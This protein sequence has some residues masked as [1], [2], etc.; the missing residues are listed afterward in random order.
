MKLPRLRTARRILYVVGDENRP[1]LLWVLLLTIVVAFLD[2]LSIG[3][4]FPLLTTMFNPTGSG[5]S[6]A[7]SF[8]SLPLVGH[9]PSSPVVLGTFLLATFVL[10]AVVSAYS[11]RSGFRFTY[12]VQVSIAQRMLAGLFAKEYE[13]FL[14]QN[15]AVLLKN[16]TAEVQFLAGSVIL[17]AFYV[18]SQ[19]LTI[20]AMVFL[21]GVVSPAAAGISF[22]VI[23]SLMTAMYLLISRR[24]TSWGKARE[25]R[26]S[27]L[28]RLAHEA[29]SGVKTVK[30]MGT[31]D[32]Y[33]ERFARV[34]HDYARLNTN[35][36]TAGALPPLFIELIV[37]GGV[38]VVLLAAA[39]YNLTLG[40]LIPVLGVLGAA[41]YRLLPAA[42]N[43]FGYIVTIRYYATTIQVVEDALKSAE[44]RRRPY[45][46]FGSAGALSDT[47]PVPQL[48][49]EITLDGVAYG[50]PDT[51]DAALKGVSLSIPAGS[52]VA[53]VGSSGSGKTTT[54]D[55]VMGLLSPTHG[56]LLVDGVEVTEKNVKGW[57][58]QLGYVSQ[59]I[60]LSD[61]SLL[62][63]ITLGIP[64]H[65]VDRA[66]LEDVL[67]QAHL[68]SFI[69]GLPQGLNT[70]AGEGGVRLS[71]GERQRVGI[72]R[73][74]YRRPRVLVLD[75]ATSSLDTITERAVNTE[76]LA[77]CVGM[78]V[79]IVAHRLSTVR[80]CD[81]LVLMDG[82]RVKATGTYEELLQGSREFAEMHK[83]GVA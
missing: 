64:E 7:A 61:G 26:L 79:I 59:D 77:A 71:G 32:V 10:K 58:A 16:V 72:A 2:F 9:I 49:Q 20:I 8:G 70:S 36:Q 34:G 27:E 14:S 6:V 37:F 83:Q 62:E 42:K 40:R 60:F 45:R 57:R 13:Y 28:N 76:V 38:T 25:Q 23:G 22:V 54:I 82:G 15:S 56:A 74:L 52:H 67:R 69:Q 75:E 65:L 46:P 66:H 29:I 3:G 5:S 78:T 80:N 41:S 47:I 11:F 31:E 50:Y 18:I 55:V 17:S 44:T 1:Q 73:A 33:L 48:A 19:S 53:L 4:L 21:L 39:A 63:N 43:I 68:Q 24:L 35:Y 12:E 30:A 51:R 81:R